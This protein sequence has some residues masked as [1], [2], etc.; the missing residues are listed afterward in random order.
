MSLTVPIRGTFF[1]LIRQ[2]GHRHCARCL[3]HVM[4]HLWSRYISVMQIHMR[5]KTQTS[6]GS[7]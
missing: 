3:M 7:Q 1:F 6:W 2:S 4:R 5:V